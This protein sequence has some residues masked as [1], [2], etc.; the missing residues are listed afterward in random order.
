MLKGG[1][2]M[3][4]ISWSD[5]VKAGCPYA[6]RFINQC[7]RRAKTWPG[8]SLLEQF[9]KILG[10]KSMECL[11]NLLSY[12]KNAD[13][14]PKIRL[15]FFQSLYHKPITTTIQQ[16]HHDLCTMHST[17]Q[18]QPMYTCSTTSKASPSDSI[19]STPHPLLGI[20]MIFLAA[21][22]A[23]WAEKLCC[24]RHFGPLAVNKN[25]KNNNQSK[26]LVHRMLVRSGCGTAHSL[27][28]RVRRA[29]GAEPGKPG[30]GVQW[31]FLETL[32]CPYPFFIKFVCP[33]RCLN[34]EVNISV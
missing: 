1:E 2:G 33:L 11:I 25:N 28:F 13:G 4:S 34:F 24:C 22:H 20:L 21:M 16:C 27:V 30:S 6:V 29:A 7:T 14:T 10:S 26:Y 23:W 12:G 9:P 31:S 5:G 17:E 3:S 18:D 19:H 32:Q 15:Q 8:P